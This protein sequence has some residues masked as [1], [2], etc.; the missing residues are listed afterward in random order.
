M[1]A[2][3]ARRRNEK[4]SRDMNGMALPG[5]LMNGNGTTGSVVWANGLQGN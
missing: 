4:T 3:Q 1:I 5:L 2:M